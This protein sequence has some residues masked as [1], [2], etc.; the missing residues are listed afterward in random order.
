MESRTSGTN[1]RRVQGTGALDGDVELFRTIENTLYTAVISDA[2][3]ELGLHDQAMYEYLRPLFPEAKCFGRARTIQCQDVFFVPEN[4]YGLEIEAIDSILSGEVVVVSTG[5][6]K[7][8]APWGELLSTAARAR[9]A[10]GAIVD[11]LVR[12]VKTI[13]KLG[14]PVFAAGI[15]PVDSMGRGVVVDY[16]IPV[17]CGGIVINPEDLIF[18]DY[19]GVVVVPHNSLQ[20]TLR[21]ARSK[22]M[23]ENHSREELMRGAYLSEVFAKYGVL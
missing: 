23:K 11:G 12:D 18:A 6:S 10:R 5:E 9:G 3:D 21:L 4:P 7:R 2:L 15:K 1:G 22:V 8:N 16:N 17:R 14:F 20:D 13:Q 19:D